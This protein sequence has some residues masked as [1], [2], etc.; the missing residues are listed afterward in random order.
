MRLIP[1]NRQSGFT[2]TEEAITQNK[3]PGQTPHPTAVQW[4]SPRYL[5]PA[6][7]TKLPR[8]SKRQQN[9]NR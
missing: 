4:L 6:P 3:R 5:D 1:V 8:Q 7:P 2:E 9:R